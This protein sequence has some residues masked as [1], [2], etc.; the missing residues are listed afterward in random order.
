MWQNIVMS[1]K[2]THRRISFLNISTW[3]SINFQNA[4]SPLI[5]QLIFFHNHSIIILILII[6]IVRFNIYTSL[7]NKNISQEILESHEL[8]LFWTVL[9]TLILTFIGFPSIRLLYLLDEVYKPT[10]TIKTIAHQ[11]YWSYEYSDFNK[12]EF[13]SFIIPSQEIKNFNS[14]LIETDNRII[15]PQNMQIRNLISSA[16]VLHSWTIPSLGVKLDAVP[17]RLNQTNFYPSSI[18]ITYGQCSE[19]CG[20]NH[21]F[22]PI[23]IEIRNTKNFLS[24]VNKIISSLSGW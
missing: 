13:D 15:I 1:L 11:W 14:R 23:S 16:D 7:V 21:R 19:I 12:F 24:W 3:G 22:M 18:G 20:A 2:F 10:M 9:P 5:E 17:G 6:S 4:R 8:E